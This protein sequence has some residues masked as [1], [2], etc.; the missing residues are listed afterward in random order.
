M[1]KVQCMYCGEQIEDSV[2]YCTACGKPSHFQKRGVSIKKQT[3]FIIYFVC[4]VVFVAIMIIWLP[5]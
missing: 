1:S 3:K 4:L 5:R 2:E